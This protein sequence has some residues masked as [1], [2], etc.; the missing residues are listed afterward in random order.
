MSLDT[1]HLK[2][3]LLKIKE[4]LSRKLGLLG[5]SIMRGGGMPLRASEDIRNV[6]QKY[7]TKLGASGR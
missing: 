6:Q 4:A 7:I 2:T 5:S 1:L 3:G